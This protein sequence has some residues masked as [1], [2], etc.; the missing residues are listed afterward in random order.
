MSSFWDDWFKR[1]RDRRGFFFPDIDR[2]ID[3]M[4][5]EMADAFKDIEESVPRDMVRVRRL[6]D[7]SIRRE[8]GPF[9][10]GYSV[11]IGPDGKPIIREFG[12]LRPGLG[13]EGQPPLNLRD[14]R[15]P[16]VDVIDEDENI[17]VVAELPGVNKEDIKLYVK[18]RSL[19]I[20]VDTPERRYYKELDFPVE[21][22]ESSATSTYKNGVL[23]TILVKRR[24]RGRGTPIK[25][26]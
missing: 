6:P 7:G 5:K 22:D 13:G 24:P 18:E 25:I 8:Y 9:V 2:M 12:N 26:E 20:D 4:E 17:K 11:K 3:E 10:Y 1:F 15:E 16:L 23:E 19:T 21:V 14:Q